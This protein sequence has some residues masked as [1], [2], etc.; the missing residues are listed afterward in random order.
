VAPAP[1]RHKLLAAARLSRTGYALTSPIAP[2]GTAVVAVAGFADAWQTP[3][4][5]IDGLPDDLVCTVA[6]LHRY[7]HDLASLVTRHLAAMG[8]P[9][10]DRDDVLRRWPFLGRAGT[11]VK[12]LKP[13]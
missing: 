11:R 12:V 2:D 13:L 7:V 6:A 4:L 9:G 5:R 3:R 1:L 8:L 10:V